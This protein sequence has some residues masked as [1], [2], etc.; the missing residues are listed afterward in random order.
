MGGGDFG[1]SFDFLIT[2]TVTLF[3][4]VDP[5]GV[6]PIFASLTTRCT[7]PQRV[8]IALK[9]T[10]IGGLILAG[11][12]LIGE[13]LLERVGI[14]MA[15]FRTAGGAL[16][17]LIGL[18]MVFERRTRRRSRSA[19]IT[20]TEQEL[21]HPHPD[22][23]PPDDIAVFPLALP[24]LAGPGALASIVLLMGANDGAIGSQAVVLIALTLVMV[25]TFFLL[26]FSARLLDWAGESASI[27]ITRLMGMILAALSVQFIF[28]GIRNGLL[29]PGAAQG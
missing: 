21:H 1:F 9:G 22:D 8:S 7:F 14:S 13:A 2:A 28:D 17:F 16:L 15:A 6:T 25:L 24:L 23:S 3:V 20:M 18:E 12:A 29:L 10:V 27:V 5:L 26:I 19:E 4:V 11:F